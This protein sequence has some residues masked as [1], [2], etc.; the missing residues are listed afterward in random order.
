MITEKDF[1]AGVRCL[2]RDIDYTER[3]LLDFPMPNGPAPD[4]PDR[5]AY[6]RIISARDDLSERLQNLHDEYYSQA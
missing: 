6:D 3:K 4:H 2:E 5:D 1:K